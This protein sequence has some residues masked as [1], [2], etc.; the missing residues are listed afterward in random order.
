MFQGLPGNYEAEEGNPPGLEP[1]RV[2]PGR[3]QGERAPN[4]RHCR[5]APF[6]CY[7][8]DL[9]T[10]PQVDPPKYK[11]SPFVIGNA[12]SGSFHS[13]PLFIKEINFHIGNKAK[14]GRRKAFARAQ[15][16][17][18]GAQKAS[19]G[20]Q[21]AFAR[22]QKAFARAQE[23]SAGAQKASAGAQ[24]AFARVQKAS[25]RAQKAFA[26]A[27]KASAGAPSQRP[28]LKLKIALRAA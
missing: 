18:A 3:L 24:K 27:Q 25:A 6:I 15:K 16:A 5:A 22:A 12:V 19:A 11:G 23:A 28:G 10:S 14:S 1:F 13:K 21:K 2:F 7:R 20:A 8:R 4:E 9:G 26:C 17:S